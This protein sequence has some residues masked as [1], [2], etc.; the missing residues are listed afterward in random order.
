MRCQ[1]TEAAERRLAAN[2]FD[3]LFCTATTTTTTTGITAADAVIAID[4]IRVR[5][6]F[7]LLMPTDTD[8]HARMT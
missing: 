6:I 7:S 1:S 2:C 3:N 4:F 8:M 5:V